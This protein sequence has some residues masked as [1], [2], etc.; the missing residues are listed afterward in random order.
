MTPHVLIYARGF[1]KPYKEQ[2][3]LSLPACMLFGK[4]CKICS[5]H[6]SG[7]KSHEN[8]NTVYIK[9]TAAFTRHSP[10]LFNTA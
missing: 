10:S 5:S 9:I 4:F 6:I 3:G 8:K 1:R 2:T 7:P